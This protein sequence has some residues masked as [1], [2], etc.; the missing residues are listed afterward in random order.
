[1]RDYTQ[2]PEGAVKEVDSGPRAKKTLLKS[3]GTGLE[4]TF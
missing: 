3:R 2:R 4:K 1:V